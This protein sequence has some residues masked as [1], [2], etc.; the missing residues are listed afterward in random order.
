MPLQS[1]CTATASHS[2]NTQASM[3][4]Q[5]LRQYSRS[6]CAKMNKEFSTL[7]ASRNHPAQTFKKYIKTSTLWHW[8]LTKD[9]HHSDLA[10]QNTKLTEHQLFDSLWVAL[11]GKRIANGNEEVWK[12]NMTQ[13]VHLLRDCVYQRVIIYGV[14]V[15]LMFQAVLDN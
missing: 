12:K 7:T 1:S 5:T 6:I 9:N 2:C 13:I 10:T 3:H 8:Q 15:T 11:L 4:T 14:F